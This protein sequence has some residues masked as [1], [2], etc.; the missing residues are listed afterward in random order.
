MITGCPANSDCTAIQ[1]SPPKQT[2]AFKI[3]AAV[4][5]VR[6]KKFELI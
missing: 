5:I 3:K 6:V 4:F 2:V 1:N